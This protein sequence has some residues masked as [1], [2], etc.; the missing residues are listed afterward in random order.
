MAYDNA[1][2]AHV[3]AQQNKTAGKSANG[4]MSF[5]GATLYSYRTPIGRFVHTVDG[6]RAV[7][8]TSN[9]YSMTTSSKHMPALWRAIDYG[10]GA[11]SPCFAVPFL[12]T[13]GSYWNGEN[14][15]YLVREYETLA[16]KLRRMRDYWGDEAQLIGQLA[17][18]ANI[19]TQYAVAFGLELPDLRPT[20]D[21]AEIWK[22]R[23]EREARLNA[24]GMAEKRER[25]RERRAERKAE[26]ERRAREE[27][28]AKH[29][30]TLAKW[31]NGEN[32][33]L[34]HAINRDKNGGAL[35][36]VK[37]DELQTS[38]GASV[39]LDHAIRVF[40]FVK[41]CRERGERWQ[42]NGRTLRVGHFQ[43]DWTDENG[44]FRAGCHLINW[45]EIER[46]AIA[47]NVFDIAGDDTRDA[48][49]PVAA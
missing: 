25:E 6:R 23:Q 22:Y 1:M 4:N 31:R 38:L 16:G 5:E 49:I 14:L 33:F 9:H 44:N 30:E 18:R 40:R 24:P 43:V 42:R 34:P 29:A 11:F 35:L 48:P 47:A 3:W 32:V 13:D 36:R 45:P 20:T 39:P 26:K 12:D 28:I 10:R 2:T 7:L 41:L 15:K 21:G 8:V 27:M 19:A 37:G 17:E 46:A